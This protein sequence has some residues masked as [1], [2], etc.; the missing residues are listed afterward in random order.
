MIINWKRLAKIYR[1][2]LNECSENCNECFEFGRVVGLDEGAAFAFGLMGMAEAIR[3]RCTC[4]PGRIDWAD[5]CERCKGY[6]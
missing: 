3:N 6:V 1:A 5:V 4:P 2:R